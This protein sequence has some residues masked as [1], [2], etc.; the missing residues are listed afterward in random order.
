MDISIQSAPKIRIKINN[1]EQID[2]THMTNLTR[3][4]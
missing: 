4:E 2:M 3:S 1:C